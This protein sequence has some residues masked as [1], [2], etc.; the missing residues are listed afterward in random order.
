MTSINRQQLI[1]AA[2]EA[3]TRAYAPYSQFAV[4]AAV[5]CADGQIFQGCNIEN[6]AY[7]STNCA[8]RVAIQSAWAVGQRDIIALAV[9]ADTSGPVSPCGNCRQVMSELTPRAVIWLTNMQGHVL[10]TT[11]QQL[12]PGAFDPSDLPPTT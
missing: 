12:L 7:P 2:I 9:V 6:A 11:P 4:G 3:R 10:E 5:L 8:E 1:D